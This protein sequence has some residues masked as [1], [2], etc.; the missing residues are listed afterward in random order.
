[1]SRFSLFTKTVDLASFHCAG[2]D[3]SDWPG[4]SLST[5]FQTQTQLL[6]LTSGR[7]PVGRRVPHTTTDQQ[8]RSREK[9]QTNLQMFPRANSTSLFSLRL[10]AVVVRPLAAPD[11]WPDG[12]SL[13][14]TG[15]TP[16]AAQ[17]KDDIKPF[18]PCRPSGRGRG[19]SAPSRS[20]WPLAGR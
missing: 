14:G 11:S 5:L 6:C 12:H 7:R 8:E 4:R 20:S 15:L 19:A 18:I 16:A 13:S 1:M 10:L 2:R 3:L 17:E 9:L